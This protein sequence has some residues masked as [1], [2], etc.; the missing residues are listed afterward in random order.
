MMRIFVS[1]PDDIAGYI[2]AIKLVN[3]GHDVTLLCINGAN[4]VV[5][6]LTVYTSPQEAYL[7]GHYDLAISSGILPRDYKARVPF[8]G[9]SPEGCYDSITL[10]LFA[11][12]KIPRFDE[13]IRSFMEAPST[14]RIS[15]R[16]GNTV[17]RESALAHE[18]LD[19]LKGLEIGASSQNQFGLSG[20]LYLDYSDN[21]KNS[22]FGQ[23]QLRDTGLIYPVDVVGDGELLPFKD[24]SFDYVIN[25]HVLE[26][27]WDVKSAIDEWMRVSR[28]FV[29][30]VVPHKDRCGESDRPT[31]TAEIAMSRYK[32]PRPKHHSIEE[33]LASWRTEDFLC[34]CADL[35]YNV[36]RYQDIDDKVGIG[37]T[38]VLE[39]KNPGQ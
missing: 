15:G 17:F 19:G 38:I 28:K 23:M 37:F 7:S 26:H 27:I 22:Y 36:L 9:V 34:M 11:R 8:T 32:A 2:I 25:S 6:G 18:L 4:L 21:T 24:G 31:Y 29:F 3:L 16:T 5:L 30:I 14:T 39:S 10:E 1:G 33:H 20:C 35:G 13:E 12:S